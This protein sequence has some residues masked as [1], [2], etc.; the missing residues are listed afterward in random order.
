MA[1]A[2]RNLTNSVFQSDSKADP[3]PAGWIKRLTALPTYG[4]VPSLTWWLCL[5]LFIALMIWQHVK[6]GYTFPIPWPDES[7]FLWQAN[8]FSEHFSL[9][10]PQLNPERS[11]FWMPPGFMVL[12]GLLFKITGASLA[13]A[14][15]FSLTM[16]ISAFVCT[17]MLLRRYTL[18][19]TSLLLCGLFFTGPTFVAIGNVARPE[20]LLLAMVSGGYLLLFSA[21]RWKGLALLLLAPLVHPIGLLF[22]IPVI[23]VLAAGDSAKKQLRSLTRLDL[24]LL[25]LAATFWLIYVVYGLANW[26]HLLHDMGF[27]ISRKA[28]R[29]VYSDVFSLE[30]LLVLLLTLTLTVHTLAEKLGSSRLLVFVL[31]AWL[32]A[33]SGR[34]MWYESYEHF[35]ILVIAVVSMH[36]LYR[37]LMMRQS[38]RSRITAPALTSIFALFVVIALYESG[39]I[40]GIREYPASF[41][42]KSMSISD[43]VPYI[44]QSDLDTVISA[45]GNKIDPDGST[46]VM[47]LPRSDAFLFPDA[48][49]GMVR[50]IHP[51]F[52]DMKPDLLVF[53]RSRY[54]PPIWDSYTAQDLR[55]LGQSERKPIFERDKQERWFFLV[56]IPEPTK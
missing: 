2:H 3:H 33:K 17:A 21:H 42:W 54:Q 18:P 6:A 35:A 13:A 51:L 55:S 26:Q 56:P 14:R 38:V 44:L 32:A 53:H 25:S 46:T 39:N 27:Q 45:L 11:V 30:S 47:F 52:C 24:V 22:L 4:R 8:G 15:G 29:E 19:L 16:L 31:P 9:F 10:A 43:K 37:G 50:V 48:L 7:H 34:E 5:G 36:V 12:V 49:K 1:V 20:A 41:R 23:P 40:P 28:D